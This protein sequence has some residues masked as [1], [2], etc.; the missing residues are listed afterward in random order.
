[1]TILSSESSIIVLESVNLDKRGW[2]IDQSR[3]FLSAFFISNLLQ[4]LQHTR[5]RNHIVWDRE[6][7]PQIC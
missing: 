6:C 5:H 1:M 7:K 3:F 4:V 2:S